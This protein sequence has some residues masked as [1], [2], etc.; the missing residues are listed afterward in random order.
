MTP[1]F[2]QQQLKSFKAFF[3]LRT[4]HQ[5]VCGKFELNNAADQNPF[6]GHTLTL[7]DAQTLCKTSP[8]SLRREKGNGV[9]RYYQMYITT[10]TYIRSLFPFLSSYE[11][12]PLFRFQ[13]STL[14]LPFYLLSAYSLF[15]EKLL[16]PTFFFL[17]RKL[18]QVQQE[19]H[20]FLAKKTPNS[21]SYIIANSATLCT[22]LPALVP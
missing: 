9:D 4:S 11:P 12:H 17:G 15:V 8:C 5:L 6:K 1:S 7:F 16:R 14:K 18:S 21:M 2:F 19:K 13:K 22:L 20:G 3:L 10:A